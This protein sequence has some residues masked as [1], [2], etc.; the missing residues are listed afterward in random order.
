[1]V[2]LATFSI[3]A[4]MIA[5]NAA[6]P[7][8]VRRIHAAAERSGERYSAKNTNVADLRRSGVRRAPGAEDAPLM[9]PKWEIYYYNDN[10]WTQIGRCDYEYDSNGQPVSFVLD[11]EGDLS[12]TI[13]EYDE[14]GQRTLLQTFKGTGENM[15]NESKRTY[16][17]DPIA[18]NFCIERM[19]YDW[20]GSQ[21]Q[22]NYF[23]ETNEVT[24]NAAGNITEILKSLP[25]S[26][27]KMVPAYH[28]VW[29]YDDP[30]GEAVSFRY[31]MNMTGEETSWI[32][33]DNTAYSDIKWDRTDGQLTGDL[34]DM[35]EG[36]NRFS[37]VTVYYED[38][39]DGYIFVS[40]PE[41]DEPGYKLV[42]TTN[43]PDEIGM[44]EVLE[45]LD[46]DVYTLKYTAS[47]YFDPETGEISAE[48][49]YQ[50]TNITASDS[51]GNIIYSENYETLAGEEPELVSGEKYELTYDDDGNLKESLLS[52]YYYDDGEYF[53]QSR[54]VYGDYIDV[55]SGVDGV[56]AQS[57]LLINGLEASADALIA[58]FS[59]D[60]R[61]VASADGRLDLS[62]LPCG[63][64][65]VRCG[66]ESLKFI[67]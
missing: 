49:T 27:G 31:Y 13:M 58:V 11:D 1:M 44:S 47:E 50:F 17:Y 51:H 64:Y 48:P 38:Q 46:A 30:A 3:M 29:G 56:Y 59:T 2:T 35:I 65:I 8:S 32:L 39:P 66:E 21:W 36:A 60:G 63:M 9:R 25:Y 28:S 10:G 23:C 14:Y 67:R 34:L 37:S 61:L 26:T 33:Y 42:M 41:G 16:V 19:G 6:T 45:L 20:S 55:K 62:V 24:R 5:I 22:T 57:G 18:H 43:D 15:V 4:S 53:E 54:T 40:Y 7:S 52:V 12:T